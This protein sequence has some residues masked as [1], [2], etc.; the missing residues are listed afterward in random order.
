MVVELQCKLVVLCCPEFHRSFKTTKTWEGYSQQTAE[1]SY[2]NCS[3]W[4]LST[5]NKGG[6]AIRVRHSIYG[7]VDFT[8]CEAPALGRNNERGVGGSADW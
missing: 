7:W 6:G 8:L 2:K 4:T 3:A 1:M 5:V